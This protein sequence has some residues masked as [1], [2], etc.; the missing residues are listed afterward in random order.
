M[1]IKIGH[2]TSDERF[3][4]SGGESGDQNGREVCTRTWYSSPWDFVLRFKDPSKAEKAARACEAGCA[5]TNIGYDQYERNSA[6]PK[7][8]EKGWDMSKIDSPCEVDCSSFMTLCAQCAGVD[9]PYVYGNAPYTGNMRAQFTK[10]GEFEVL[11]EAKYLGSDEYLRR[12]DILVNSVRHTAMALENG[13]KSGEKNDT[14]TAKPNTP[15]AQVKIDPAYKFDK[16]L[17]KTYTVTASALNLRSGADVSKPVLKV[18][19]RGTRVTC[20]GYYNKKLDDV[21][22]Y[23]MTADGTTGYCSKKYLT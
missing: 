11:T 3:R 1:A 15:T 16:A 17:A 21:W 22:L 19:P 20:Y 4:A 14:P 2:A 7:A 10:T 23:V 13:S 5:N 6:L 9:V 12:G 8:K 18:L